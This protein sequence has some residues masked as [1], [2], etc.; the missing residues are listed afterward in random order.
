MSTPLPLRIEEAFSI[1]DKVVLLTGATG[2]IGMSIA[3]V[4]AANGA[5]LICSDR[6][7]L[8][9]EALAKECE[10]VGGKPA[11][12]AADLT[13]PESLKA[14]L[15]FVDEKFGRLDAIIHCG[16]IASS[17]PF[18]DDKEENFDLIFHTNVR[19]LWLLA[20]DSV[21]LFD[22][23]G[24][25]TFI[26]FSSVN[27]HRP[28]IPAALY[29]SSKAAV[30]NMTQDLASELSD[31]HIRFN[32]ISPGA[33]GLEDRALAHLSEVLNPPYREQVIAQFRADMKADTSGYSSDPTEVAHALVLLVSEAG[34]RINGADLVV[35]GG[36]MIRQDNQIV[37]TRN[38]HHEKWDKA[39]AVLCALPKEAWKDGPPAW[40][41]RT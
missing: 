11:I 29:S 27:G 15:A 4:F 23:A 40:V 25:G 3:H 7:M 5:R 35:D 9:L 6:E 38:Q 28:F 1:R 37:Q 30:M 20:R 13:S 16:A 17:A 34:R 26:T 14:L 32:T 22:K 33:T 19:S 18:D 2:I 31:H 24:G 39:H 8:K 12:C 36:H 21:A 41:T 10:A